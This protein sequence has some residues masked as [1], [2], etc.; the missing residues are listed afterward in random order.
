VFGGAN[1]PNIFSVARHYF[2]FLRFLTG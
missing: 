2:A 1:N